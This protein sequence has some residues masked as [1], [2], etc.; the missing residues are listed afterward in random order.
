MTRQSSGQASATYVPA[1][2]HS[3]PIPAPA[4]KRYMPKL[5]TLCA[6]DARAVKIEKVNIVAASTFVRPKRSARGPHMNDNPQPA[7]KTA[8]RIDPAK[9]MFPGLAAKPD[10]GSNS[11]S[12]GARTSAY[13]KES[14]P[15]SV[16]PAHARSEERRV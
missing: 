14:M 10:F 7:K 15:S 3:P 5:Q 13:I 8:N 16:H 1:R 9:P 11:A 4:I 12:A 6:V 2:A